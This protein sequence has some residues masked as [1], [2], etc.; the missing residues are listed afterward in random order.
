MRTHGFSMA[1]D[2]F[3]VKPG[4]VRMSLELLAFVVCGTFIALLFA[5]PATWP[6]AFGAGLGWTTLLAQHSSK[7]K[8]S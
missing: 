1:F 5:Q 2:R 8:E 4:R 3:D 6:Q 7:E